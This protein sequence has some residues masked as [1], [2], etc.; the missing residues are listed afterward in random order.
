[1]V[2]RPRR[3]SLSRA[4]VFGD[5]AEQPVLFIGTTSREINSVTEDQHI[6]QPI[7][8]EG[9]A[10]G[11]V[12]R[13]QECAGRGVIA[14]D[15]SVAKI[16]DPQLVAFYQ[17]K[18]PW[19]IEAAVGNE[20]PDEIAAGVEDIYETVTQAGYVVRLLGVL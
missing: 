7:K 13:S 8:L 10:I 2:S 15:C 14:G 11:P 20:T 19:R 16:S 6:P 5:Q 12:D 4:S 17:S 9:S 18:S 3:I 1:M